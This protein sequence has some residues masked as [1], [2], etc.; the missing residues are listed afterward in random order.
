MMNSLAEK[1]RATP[2]DVITLLKNHDN[3]ISHRGSGSSPTNEGTYQSLVFDIMG[4]RIFVSDGRTLPVSLS[5]IYRE[6]SVDV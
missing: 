6:I 2:E 3:G 5:G 1:A 4:R